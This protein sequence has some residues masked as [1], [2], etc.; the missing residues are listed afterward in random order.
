MKAM[1]RLPIPTISLHRVEDAC[2][3][4]FV[5]RCPLTALA[6]DTECQIPTTSLVMLSGRDDSLYLSWH[7]ATLLEPFYSAAQPNKFDD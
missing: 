5:V 6:V 4:C 2:D 7:H 1:K 3:A